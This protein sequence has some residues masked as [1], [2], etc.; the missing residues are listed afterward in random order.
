MCFPSPV[1]G[2]ASAASGR[3]PGTKYTLCRYF[4]SDFSLKSAAADAAADAST[5][6]DDTG[7]TGAIGAISETVIARVE[8][9]STHF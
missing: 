8:T 6:L 5:A 7:N 4:Q 1:R 2:A 3:M 9:F